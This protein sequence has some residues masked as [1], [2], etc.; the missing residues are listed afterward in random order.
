MYQLTPSIP[1]N[2]YDTFPCQ[3]AVT[4][5][6]CVRQW[7]IPKPILRLIIGEHTAVVN[8][9]KELSGQYQIYNGPMHLITK[10]ID[11]PYN[12]DIHEIEIIML[13]HMGI[14]I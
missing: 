4:F 2:Q 5:I 1:F 12:K 9:I 3:S 14:W 7:K 13:S 11:E 10:T 8:Q 6:L